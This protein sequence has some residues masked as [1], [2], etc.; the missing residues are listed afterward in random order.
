MMRKTHLSNFLLFKQENIYADRKYKLSKRYIIVNNTK[1]WR[2]QF[3]YNIYQSSSSWRYKSYT[4]NRTC[5]KLWN[6]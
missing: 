6:L 2:S 1:R 4:F 5:A 3:A